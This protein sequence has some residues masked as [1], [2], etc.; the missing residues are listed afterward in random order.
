MHL[1]TL[2]GA[3]I[4]IIIMRLHRNLWKGLLLGTVFAHFTRKTW[5]GAEN[6]GKG[7]GLGLGTGKK[8]VYVGETMVRQKEVAGGS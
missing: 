3:I 1:S 7:L 2:T 4:I 8:Q 5:A 6:L